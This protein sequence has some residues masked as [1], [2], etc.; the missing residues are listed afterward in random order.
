M[1]ILSHCHYYG[2]GWRWGVY[3]TPRTKTS[4]F[5]TQSV[6]PL[7]LSSSLP[8]ITNALY[9]LIGN[10]HRNKLS[11]GPRKMIP[12]HQRSLIICIIWWPFVPLVGLC[13]WSRC[14]SH[15][16]SLPPSLS[17]FL[18]LPFISSSLHS[19]LRFLSSMASSV[20]LPFVRFL[21]DKWPS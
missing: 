7:P 3:P 14:F 13:L 1:H 8:F 10:A 17:S 6:R 12:A 19:F 21:R 18:L 16:P 4:V 9:S 15:S 20:R 2:V 11:S 5:S